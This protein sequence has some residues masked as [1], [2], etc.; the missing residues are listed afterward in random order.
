MGRIGF[1]SRLQGRRFAPQK[2]DYSTN[3]DDVKL[4]FEIAAE[5]TRFYKQPQS[6]SGS[7]G[8]NSRS[9]GKSGRIEKV[10]SDDVDQSVAS[11]NPKKRVSKI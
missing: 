8:G 4:E 5:V 6:G 3:I 1:F 10:P 2:L 7:S 9:S 11:T